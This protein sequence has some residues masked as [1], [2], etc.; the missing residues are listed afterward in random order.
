MVILTPQQRVSRRQEKRITKSFKE[1]QE[2]ARQTP[3]SGNQWHSKSDVVTELFRI[4][5]KTKVK[6]SK[7]IIL[8]KEYFDKIE[9]E[10]FETGKL[11]MVAFSFGDQKD[12][13]AIEATEFIVLMEEL[14]EYRKR[15]KDD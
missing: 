13:L 4:E 11:G 7:S 10:A 6:P 8:K 3:G 2:S 15:G 1:I 9:L 12:Y 5:A 14:L